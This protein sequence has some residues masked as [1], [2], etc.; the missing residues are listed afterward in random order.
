MSRTI[1]HFMLPALPLAI[2]LLLMQP[3][4]AEDAK[5]VEVKAGDITLTVPATWKSSKPTNRLRLAQFTIPAVGGDT[6]PGELVIYFFG[7]S[8]GGIDANLQRWIDSF[9]PKGRIVRTLEGTSKQGKYVLVDV[10]GTYNKPVGP[11]VQ[12]QTKPAPGSRMLAV[13]L[14][15]EGKG[16]YFLKLTGEEKT[17]TA[18]NKVL[19]TSFGASIDKE[20][21][22]KLKQ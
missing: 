5:P 12:R 21:D 1:T 11:P 10:K 22:Y 13:V 14:N 20:K 2:A 3:L 16:N 9:Q 8:G 4:Q 17:I 7:G 19:R 15:V 6:D 18:I